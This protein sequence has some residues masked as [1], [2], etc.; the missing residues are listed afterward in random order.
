MSTWRT[1]PAASFTSLASR[2]PLKSGQHGELGTVLRYTDGW[3][4][5]QH[6]MITDADPH[7]TLYVGKQRGK[8]GQELLLQGHIYLE[9]VQEDKEDAGEWH[10][11]YLADPTKRYI[12][13]LESRRLQRSGG[14]QPTLTKRL[15][16]QTISL[17][18]PF[19][20]RFQF[21]ELG[22]FR[23]AVN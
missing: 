6:N 15:G 11:S 12:P 10:Y 5:R 2:S 1:P 17:A 19:V 14:S 3:T 18:F 21:K 22:R 13:S 20:E 8:R 9:K 4:G 16:E 7:I 23:S